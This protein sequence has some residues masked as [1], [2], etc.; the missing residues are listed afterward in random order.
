MRTKIPDNI[1]TTGLCDFSDILFFLNDREESMSR[2]KKGEGLLLSNEQL[3]KMT[4]LKIDEY[5]E[6]VQF[7]HNPSPA[8]TRELK[9]QRRRVFNRAY[10]RDSRSKKKQELYDLESENAVLY[11]E[12]EEWRLR[13]ISLEKELALLKKK[14]KKEKEG[15]YVPMV[16]SSREESSSP[17]YTDC[18]S[19]PMELFDLL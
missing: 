10:A 13:T 17:S 12:K 5:I 9:D 7:N 2:I 1:S 18:P 16:T 14:R 19:S 11:E 4:P 6:W 15:R 8:E 3:L